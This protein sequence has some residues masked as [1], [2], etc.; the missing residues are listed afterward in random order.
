MNH[1]AVY[2][3]PSK[4]YINIE[5]DS[6][7]VKKKVRIYTIDGKEIYSNEVPENIYNLNINLKHKGI[8]LIEIIENNIVQT[9][10]III[11]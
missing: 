11:E 10:K 9:Q 2:P 7:Q 1:F 5:F 3:N 8:C 6:V 4:G